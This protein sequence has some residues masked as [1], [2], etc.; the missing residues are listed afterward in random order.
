MVWQGPTKD[1]S[2]TLLDE[3]TPQGF[4]GHA[5][6]WPARFIWILYLSELDPSA[7]PA[8]AILASVKATASGR[9][10]VFLLLFPGGLE[11]FWRDPDEATAMLF[12]NLL[13]NGCG[14]RESPS[15]VIYGI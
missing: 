4:Q 2:F 12:R 9:R 1:G 10:V 7:I 6:G 3:E 14:K 5:F 13:G 11:A 15:P 8:C